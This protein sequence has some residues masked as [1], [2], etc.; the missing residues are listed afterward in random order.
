MPRAR[1]SSARLPTFWRKAERAPPTSAAMPA[2][3]I[4]APRSLRQ[5]GDLAR[6]C[7]RETWV[8]GEALGLGKAE[9]FANDVR[10]KNHRDHLVGGVPA[11]HS[12]AA[13]AAIG[14]DHQPFRRSIFQRLA[15]QRGDLIG[16]LDLQCVMVDDADDDLLVLDGLADRLEVA[17]AR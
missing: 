14:G 10:A 5:S 9:F 17:G 4:W 13:H 11:A 15:D 6:A 3:R 7:Q 8:G 12:F 16:P 1:L 2:Q